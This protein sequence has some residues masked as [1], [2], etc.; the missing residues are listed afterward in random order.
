[1]STTREIYMA[2][3]T[4]AGVFLGAGGL[5]AW[6]GSFYDGQVAVMVWQDASPAELWLVQELRPVTHTIGLVLDQVPGPWGLQPGEKLAAVR[7]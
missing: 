6:Q 7:R 2:A 1:M 3:S 4:L 5:T